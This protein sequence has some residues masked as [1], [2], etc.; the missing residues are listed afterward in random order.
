M[1]IYIEVL[2]YQIPPRPTTHSLSCMNNAQEKTSCTKLYI[3]NSIQNSMVIRQKACLY[4]G[5]I[6][7][8]I[9]KQWDQYRLCCCY[10]T[11]VK[12]VAVAVGGSGPWTPPALMPWKCIAGSILAV[13]CQCEHLWSTLALLP[14]LRNRW[15]TGVRRVLS[16][17]STFL[18][19]SK[20]QLLV[21]T[22]QYF[23]AVSSTP[24]L[25]AALQIQQDSSV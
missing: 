19:G 11:S 7:T 6:Q 25:V 12:P 3:W 17:Y 10:F 21:Y 9:C 4:S 1:Q 16:S 20:R 22:S 24:W 18:V 2:Y 15:L 5:G 13:N 14:S 8:C 23:H